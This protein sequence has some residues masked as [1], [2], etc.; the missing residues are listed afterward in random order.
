MIIMV[1]SDERNV[2]RVCIR[3]GVSDGRDD[4]VWVL[5]DAVDAIL[6]FF[7]QWDILD[8]ITDHVYVF[9]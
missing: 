3:C 1:S 7:F 5:E 4:I 2:L 9:V 8:D 6:L